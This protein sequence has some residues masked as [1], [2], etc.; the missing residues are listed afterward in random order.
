VDDHYN[1][2]EGDRGSTLHCPKMSN[3]VRSGTIEDEDSRSAKKN[4]EYRI[5]PYHK[6]RDQKG[7]QTNQ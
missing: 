7:C 4:K 1:D 2:H 5:S 6:G 3:V